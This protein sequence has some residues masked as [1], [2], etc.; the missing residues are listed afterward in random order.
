M[1]AL[2]KRAAK[3]A[4]CVDQATHAALT[5]LRGRAELLKRLI[6]SVDWALRHGRATAEQFMDLG[7]RR[8]QLRYISDRIAPDIGPPRHA[9]RLPATG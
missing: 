5:P 3:A 9:P 1:A 4:R 6:V 2:G 8:C 7:R